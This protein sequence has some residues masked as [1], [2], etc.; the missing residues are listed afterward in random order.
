MPYFNFPDSF[1]INDI[2]TDGNGNWV[3]AWRKQVYTGSY[4]R[5]V[6]EAF[7]IARSSDNGRTWIVPEIEW[8]GDYWGTKIQTDEKG[9]WVMSFLLIFLR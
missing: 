4:Y 6:A 1:G 5:G 8:Y 3:A 7:V 2:A 9:H